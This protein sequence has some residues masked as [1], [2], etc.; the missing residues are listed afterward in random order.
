MTSLN[1]LNDILAAV[2]TCKKCKLYTLRDTCVF[3]EG[4][5]DAKTMLIGL[6]PGKEENSTG[7]LFV[8]P[9]GDFLNELLQ[10]AKMNREA[11]YITN[12]IKCHYFND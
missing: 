4:E 5:R 12:I 6:S 3:A 9:S 1:N 7:R 2:E 8:G 11:L 10:L